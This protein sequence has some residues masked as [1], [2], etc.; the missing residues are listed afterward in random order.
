ML[1]KTDVNDGG[2]YVMNIRKAMTMAMRLQYKY[3]YIYIADG[4][5]TYNRPS[6]HPLTTKAMRLRPP[7]P[8]KNDKKTIM[9][10]PSTVD[11]V[12]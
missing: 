11:L 3:I 12:V 9:E 4:E 5:N 6:L 1:M 10:T 8:P 2:Y 7:R